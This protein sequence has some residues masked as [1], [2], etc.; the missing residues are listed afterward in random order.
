MIITSRLIQRTM[1][2]RDLQIINFLLP[3]IVG[4]V[5]LHDLHRSFHIS[6]QCL[7]TLLKVNNW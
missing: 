3:S 5:V 2:F 4:I 6:L 1:I 7:A